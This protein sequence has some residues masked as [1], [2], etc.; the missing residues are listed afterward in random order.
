MVAGGGGSYRSHK[1]RYILSRVVS[2]STWRQATLLFLVSF[3]R[4]RVDVAGSLFK[5]LLPPDIFIYRG[6]APFSS[7]RPLTRPLRAF[8][9]FS[10]C[11]C[12]TFTILLKLSYTSEKEGN[13]EKRTTAVTICYNL[14]YWYAFLCLRWPTPTQPPC[15]PSFSLSPLLL[16]LLWSFSLSLLRLFLPRYILCSNTDNHSG[17]VN[18]FRARQGWYFG[19]RCDGRTIAL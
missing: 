10:P 16:A 18:I 2:H 7:L 13:E 17:R 11:L 9:P 3:S 15:F 5:R 12:Y 8:L 1:T 4:T 14:L 6:V 19:F